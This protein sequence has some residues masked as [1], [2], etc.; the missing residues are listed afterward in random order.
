M[1]THP[2]LG[3]EWLP[4]GICLL[5]FYH[6]ILMPVRKVYGTRPTGAKG[7][8]GARALSTGHNST[9]VTKRTSTHTCIAPA[10]HSGTP[11]Y[12]NVSIAGLNLVLSAS[13][14][15]STHM[16]RLA[17]LMAV[18]KLVLSI[19]VAVLIIRVHVGRVHTAVA[20]HPRRF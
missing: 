3:T 13:T 6:N 19:I 20:A 14:K 16:G 9:L 10:D 4:T 12:T 17:I 7:Q 18:L 8:D 5:S 1:C 11:Y 15:C 2:W